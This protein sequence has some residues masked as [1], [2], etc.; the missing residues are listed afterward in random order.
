MYQAVTG[1]V[2]VVMAPMGSGKGTIIKSTL[3]HY[4]GVHMTVSCTTRT[5]RPG[6]VDGREYHFISNQEFNKKIL[7]GEFLEWANF[8]LS[9]YGTLKTEILPYLEIGKVVIAEIEVQGVEQFFTSLPKAN[10]TIVYVEAGNWEVLKARALARAKISDEELAKRYER[11]L[12]EIKAKSIADVIIDNTKPDSKEA[13]TQFS[14]VLK[15][16][17]MTIK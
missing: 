10:L 9:R 3:Q 17:Y 12:I 11:Y 5:P 7:A 15:N 2:V 13:V 16:I 4:P 1:H 8:G 14:E 6:E